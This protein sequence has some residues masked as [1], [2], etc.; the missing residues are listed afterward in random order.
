MEYCCIRMADEE[1]KERIYFYE[2]DDDFYDQ[3]GWGYWADVSFGYDSESDWVS[4]KYCPFCGGK[5][6]EKATGKKE[7]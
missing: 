6:D 7:A 1:Q 2:P 3:K 5:L 4:I